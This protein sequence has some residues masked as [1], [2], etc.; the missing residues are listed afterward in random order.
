MLINFA[1]IV[2]GANLTVKPSKIVAGQ[3]AE[4]TNELLQA[5]ALALEK[6]VFN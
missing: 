1:E 2:T 5:M 3:E 4:K 6:K